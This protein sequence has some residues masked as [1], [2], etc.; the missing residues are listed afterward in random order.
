MMTMTVTVTITVTTAVMGMEGY[1]WEDRRLEKS[2]VS[3]AFHVCAC[4]CVRERERTILIR[5]LRE[6]NK[7][8][9][10]HLASFI[11]CLQ[12]TI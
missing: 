10:R 7:R 2:V 3:C 9:D 4:V 12:L 1:L 6:G 5:R 11:F 8:H